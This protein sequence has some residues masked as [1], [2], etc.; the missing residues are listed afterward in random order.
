MKPT[1]ARSAARW[2]F[3]LAILIV[4]STAGRTQAAETVRHVLHISV[5]GLGAVYLRQLTDAHELPNFSR[6]MREG[7]GTLNA[8]TDFDYTITLPNHTSMLTGRPVKDCTISGQA[9]VGHQWVVN[10]DPGSKELHSN[11]QTYVASAFDVAHDHGLGTGLFASKTKFVLY[12]QS[13]DAVH[14]APDLVSPDNGRDKV[15]V[16]VNDKD[17]ARVVRELIAALKSA[18]LG[19][20]FVHLHDADT[21]GHKF[22]WGSPQYNAAV[23]AVD[24]DLGMIFDAIAQTASLRGSTAIILSADHGGWERNHSDN[25]NPLDYT[26]PFYVWGPGVLKGKDLYALNSSV[27]LEPGTGRPDYTAAKQPIRNGDGG[28]LAL[29]LLGL[30][31]IPESLIDARQDLAVR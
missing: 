6:L 31:P 17:S 12:D 4:A 3:W 1:T 30:G 21:A 11:R 16:Y 13:Y 20:A 2:A 7:A 14:G 24:D 18:Q 27:R 9:A 5:D 29:S 23:K 26:I 19:Y 28:N 8:R 15:D 25:A 10:T 22:G